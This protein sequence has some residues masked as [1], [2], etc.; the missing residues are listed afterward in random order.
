MPRFES[1][2]VQISR[3][4][5]EG[6]SWRCALKAPALADRG[7]RRM[8]RGGRLAGREERHEPTRTFQGERDAMRSEMNQFHSDFRARPWHGQEEVVACVTGR[9]G[10]GGVRWGRLNTGG[11]TQPLYR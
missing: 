4:L 10:S 7:M 2:G 11:L 1:N 9:V 8:S 3:R 6:D 5:A